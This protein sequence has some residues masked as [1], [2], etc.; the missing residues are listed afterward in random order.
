MS[1]VG[2]LAETDAATDNQDAP[3]ALGVDTPDAPGW[4]AIDEALREMYGQQEAWQ[5]RTVQTFGQGGGDPLDCICAYRVDGQKPHW[6]YVSYGM[7]ELYEKRSRD[8]LR[9]G[10][11]F[12]FTLRLTRQ[13]DETQ[14][15][16]WPLRLLQHLSRYVVQTGNV[17]QPGDHMDVNGPIAEGFDTMLRAAMFAADPL[18]SAIDTPNGR[19]R[20]V[21]VVGVTLDELRA[22][23]AWNIT[24]FLELFSTCR[25]PLLRTDLRRRSILKHPPVRAALEIR[26]HAEGSAT[27]MVYATGVQFKES[28]WLRRSLSISLDANVVGDLVTLLSA[29]LSHGRPLTVRGQSQAVTFESGPELRW[30]VRGDDVT[31]TLPPR[32]VTEVAGSLTSHAGTYRLAAAPGLT[33][34]VEPCQLRDLAGNNVRVCGV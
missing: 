29:R 6:H 7:S 24:G 33:L 23:K 20:F 11:G 31:V 30:R 21:Q 3:E 1:N 34:H 28:G 32:A 13:G 22:A 16:V 8:R 9:S 4:D 27:R 12:E 5:W 15:P 19:V 14:P 25:D 10:W 26:S 2:L 17:F 18:L